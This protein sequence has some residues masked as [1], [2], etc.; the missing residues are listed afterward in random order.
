M[1]QLR[2][3]LFAGPALA[4]EQ[5]GNIRARDISDRFAQRPHRRTLS[6]HQAGFR[7]GF[8]DIHCNGHKRFMVEPRAP[9]VHQGNARI[10]S[11][12]SCNSGSTCNL[13]P[14]LLQRKRKWPLINN[15]PRTRRLAE[16]PT[17][18]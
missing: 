3:H 11:G 7:R 16:F 1:N 13:P 18:L 2:V 12:E 8:Q 17:Q 14:H 15:L 5:H 9:H 6:K 4:D 10:P